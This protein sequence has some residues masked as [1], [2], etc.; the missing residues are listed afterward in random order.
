MITVPYKLQFIK[1]DKFIDITKFVETF[2]KFTDVGTG[3]IVSAKIMLD[4]RA[5][6][7]ITESNADTTPIIAQYDTFLLT[8]YHNDD[9]T[10]QRFMLQD[11][12]S[13]QK[14]DEGTHLILNLLGRERYLQKMFFTGHYFWISFADM[15]TTIQKYYNDNRGTDQPFMHTY[16]ADL[17]E[18][19]KYTIG[20]FNFGDQTTVY[21]AMMEVVN[22]FKLP[23][24]SGGAG[25]FYGLIFMDDF[26]ED[27]LTY[28]V[29]PQGSVPEAPKTLPKPMLTTQVKQPS[30]GNVQIVQ[31]APGSGSLPRGPSLWRSLIEEYD[32][33][34]SWFDDVIY[35]KDTYVTYQNKV[36]QCTISAVSAGGLPSGAGWTEVKFKDYVKN[37]TGQSNFSYS[38]LTQSKAAVWKNRCGNSASGFLASNVPV[39][40]NGFDALAVWD[41]NLVIRDESAWR[42]WVDV[43]AVSEA[44][45]PPSRIYHPSSPQTSR[46]ERAYEG[47]RVLVDSS[48][49]TI[50]P[51][52]TGNDANGK[53]FRDAIVQMASDGQ[54]IVYREAEQFDQCAVIAEGM[55]YQYNNPHTLIDELGHYI[56]N[57]GI[58][59]QD[60][61][62]RK[63]G[64]R[65]PLAND[66]FHYPAVFQ[67]APGL[68]G[69]DPQSKITLDNG[70]GKK[71]T[72]NSAIHIE[73]HFG[74]DAEQSNDDIHN[75]LIKA[76]QGVN[77]IFGDP[78]S[79]Y[80]DENEL[81][82][83]T[84][85]QRNLLYQVKL[86]S[87]GWY[88]PLWSAPDPLTTDNFVTEKVGELFGGTIDDKR[89]TLD[90]NNLN[91]TPSGNTGYGHDDS[92]LLR[93]A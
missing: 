11:D 23:V 42:D 64:D 67:N 93:R 4:S 3:E 74:I 57:K 65:V 43:I 47:F 75:T 22:R 89:P 36:Y 5:G 8:L 92:D 32:N 46:S 63:T 30:L 80:T 10:F 19:P 58:V 78:F 9:T 37:E 35:K 49:G 76:V 44:D 71:F 60:L 86:Y 21:E 52:F 54:W 14:N 18:I 13:P 16:V 41:C 38:P 29:R 55:V 85:E 1:G 68:L 73:Y 25:E 83:M 12:I 90:I 91:N 69:S 7:F 45:I 2:D 17:L 6:E 24:A 82:P 31:G 26:T 40:K 61:A 66:C 20:S 88:A 27:F 70:E 48:K 15:L 50:H 84:Q 79:L 51:P 28:R 59:Q 81:K 72:D 53:S 87:N 39:N 56:T 33:L 34:A 77:A 62:W